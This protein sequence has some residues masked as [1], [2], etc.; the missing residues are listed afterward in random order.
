MLIRSCLGMIL[1]LLLSSRD[2]FSKSGQLPNIVLL[3]AD[4]LGYR[5]VS[6]YGS[7]QVYMPNLDKLAAEGIRF[8]DFYP[9]SAFET[10]KK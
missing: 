5:D 9:G 7:T 6:C 2:V 8:T 4:D 1:I 10:M 3:L